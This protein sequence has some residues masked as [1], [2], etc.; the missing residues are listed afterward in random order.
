M[1]TE[2]ILIKNGTILKTKPMKSSILIEDNIITEISKDIADNDAHTIIDAENKI[3][4]PGLIN[5]HTHLSMSIFR[6]LADDL[7]LDDWL[8][9]HI[10]PLEANLNSEYSYA[11][12]LLSC[13]E[14][15]KSGTTTL[16]DMYFYMSD[17]AKAIDKSGLRANISYGMIDLD[18]EDK[19]MNEFK[20]S[21]KLIKN[22]NNTA[23]GRIKVSFGPHSPYTCSEELL[24]KVRELANKFDVPIHI[25]VSETEKELEDI[26]E[27]KGKRPF[28]YLNDIGFLNNDVLAAHAVWLNENEMNIIK[29]K[30]VKISHNPVSNMK[31][32]SGIA[33]VN[34]MLEKG[35]C[36]SI[37][38]D[39]AA[40][41][42][43]L[44]MFE[45]MKFASLNQ[46][47]ATLDPRVASAEETLKMGTENAAEALQLENL[48]IIKEGAIADL[49]VLD[50]RAPHLNPLT[51]PFAHIVYSA[52]GSDVETT[53]CNGKLLMK[54]RELLT[55]D[56]EEC[57]AIAN[58]TSEEI[59]SKA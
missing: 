32:A 19:R 28:E 51:E 56:E 10:W 5:T 50:T 52:N 2:N 24:I 7:L 27:D 48:G 23:D 25:H 8:N 38:T 22:H 45:E 6:G 46:K 59:V 18:D 40:S 44:D 20:E 29:E 26:I 30:E 47:V 11:G 54:N 49:I 13:L 58:E 55:I 3:V 12:A 16:N 21:V 57:I 14:M 42:N 4:M 39:S 36:V 41:N 9:K 33:P 17:V 34:R 37:G 1:E 53:I 35:I 43:N 15:I 31:L